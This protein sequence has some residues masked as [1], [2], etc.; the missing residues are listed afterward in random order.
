MI[1]RINKKDILL[2]TQNKQKVMKQLRN[3]AMISAS[4]SDQERAMHSLLL[5]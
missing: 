1:K 5:W 2:E 4:L 3:F